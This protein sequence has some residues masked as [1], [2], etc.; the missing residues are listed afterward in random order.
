[1]SLAIALLSF[2]LPLS[3]VIC[4][5]MSSD[6][7]AQYMVG[8]TVEIIDI[9]IAPLLVGDI[10]QSTLYSQMM[11]NHAYDRFSQFSQWYEVSIKTYEEI[12]W[13]MFL[14]DFELYIDNTSSNTQEA[15]MTILSSNLNEMETINVHNA[16]SCL[17]SNAT[18]AKLFTQESS[19][20]NFSNFQILVLKLDNAGDIIMS[21][22]GLV[23]NVVQLKLRQLFVSFGL[24]ILKER[25]YSIHRKA[26]ANYLGDY[27]SSRVRE[28]SCK[29]GHV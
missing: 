9:Q 28:L 17:Y 24:G 7:D 21:Y 27:A 16:F 20:G 12:G 25:D 18:T 10:L 2:F 3:K 22:A 23:V 14:S 4:L 26:V 11:A 6:S 8:G 13:S 15:V 19:E 5:P 29:T 1:M